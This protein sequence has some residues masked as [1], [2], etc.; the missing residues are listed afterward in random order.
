MADS[1]LALVLAL[2]FGLLLTLPVAAEAPTSNPLADQHFFIPP[3]TPARAQVRAWG[4]T[5]PADATLIERIA[6][7]PT[8]IWLGHEYVAQGYVSSMVKKAAQQKALPVFVTYF[9]PHRDCGAYSAGGAESPADYERWV[10]KIVDAIGSNPVAIIVEP[11]A[12]SELGCWGPALGRQQ[13]DLIRYSVDAFSRLPH[14]A[15]YIDAGNRPLGNRWI[16]TMAL[17]LREAG[18]AHARGLAVNVSNYGSVSAE[19]A[20]GRRLLAALHGS[21]HFVIDTSRD[22]RGWAPGYPWCNPPGRGLGPPPTASTHD[23]LVDAYL[24]IKL[25]GSSDG[26]CNGGPPAGQWWP[27]QALELAK[28]AISPAP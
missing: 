11:D 24:W 10:R 17:K 5:R 7:Q 21:W 22:G 3:G 9:L 8:A 26:P 19:T 2:A 16:S 14:A 12:L 13:I 23:P 15:V 25:P 6:T 28:N 27:D 4:T 18:I 20:Y 1:A